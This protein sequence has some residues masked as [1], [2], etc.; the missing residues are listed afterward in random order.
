MEFSFHLA[1]LVYAAGNMD[2][3]RDTYDRIISTCS[4][5]D[6]TANY[7]VFANALIA[8]VVFLLEDDQL[9][10]A[11]RVIQQA[12]ELREKFCEGNDFKIAECKVML[13]RCMQQEDECDYMHC[14]RLLQEALESAHFHFGH[15]HAQVAD[16][17]FSLA[18]THRNLNEFEESL[19]FHHISLHILKIIFGE[20]NP[21]AITAAGSVGITLDKQMQFESSRIGTKLKHVH[22]E[23]QRSSVSPYN[24]MQKF[25]FPWIR[26]Q[27]FEDYTE[28]SKSAKKSKGGD[29]NP[30]QQSSSGGEGSH[31]EKG[32]KLLIRNI[33]TTGEG[34]PAEFLLNRGEEL[35]L[36]DCDFASAKVMFE[37]CYIYLCEAL[38][39]HHNETLNAQYRIADSLRELGDYDG[40]LETYQKCVKEYIS[41]AG[42]KIGLANAMAGWAET[43]LLIGNFTMAKQKF[44]EALVN[45]KN[46]QQLGIVDYVD[47][48]HCELGLVKVLEGDSKYVEAVRLLDRLLKKIKSEHGPHHKYFAEASLLHARCKR[49]KGS[50]AEVRASL[51]Q[52]FIARRVLY[53]ED[54]LYF[55]YAILENAEYDF[56]MGN[57]EDALSKFDSVLE[58]ALNFLDEDH[59]YVL[60]IRV[61]I[62]EVKLAQGFISEA[63]DEHEDILKSVI[64]ILGPDSGKVGD[65]YYYI[66]NALL[67]F[68]KHTEAESAFQS[69]MTIYARTYGDAHSKMAALKFSLAENCRLQGNLD[70]S[71]ELHTDVLKLRRDIYGKEHP[72]TVASMFA[73]QSFAIFDENSLTPIDE[74]RNNLTKLQNLQK[75]YYGE[76]HVTYLNSIIAFAELY[77]MYHL[78]P[79]AI[80]KYDEAIR[81]CNVLYGPEHYLIPHLTAEIAM[82]NVMNV[83]KVRE[84]LA[85][86][87]FEKEQLEAR[88]ALNRSGSRARG[89]EDSVDNST[90]TS[91]T[92]VP[93]ADDP[94]D[95]IVDLTPVYDNSEY[96]KYT[97]KIQE[98]IDAML[99]IFPETENYVHPFVAHLRGNI[100]IIEKLEEDGRR[101]FL[102]GLTRKEKALYKEAAEKKLSE[103]F[104]SNTADFSDSLPGTVV[105]N[106]A[107][108]YFQEHGFGAKHKWVQKF[109]TVLKSITSEKVEGTE[110]GNVAI[111][112]ATRKLKEARSNFVRGDLDVARDAYKETLERLPECATRPEDPV[113]FAM[114]GEC[115]CGLGDIYRYQCLMKEAREH[116]VKSLTILR[117]IDD[118]DNDRYAMAL[119]GYSDLLF[120]EGHFEECESTIDEA[121]N[122]KEKIVDSH[123]EEIIDIQYRRV[124]L[125][126][127][128]GR[129]EIGM[130]G[131]Q[132]ILDTRLR[133]MR[134]KDNM[135]LQLKIAH[136][137]NA[138]AEFSILLAQHSEADNYITLAIKVARS[139]IDESK[140][141]M[142]IADSYHLRG[143]LRMVEGK[144]KEALRNFGHALAMKMRLLISLKKKSEYDHLLDEDGNIAKD[145]PIDPCSFLHTT[146]AISLY[147]QA[148]SLRR[149][150]KF[151]LASEL[152]A[153]SAQIVRELFGD[154]D[155]P[156]TAAVWFSQAENFRL[157]GEYS[158][159]DSL[160][161]KSLEMRNRLFP[162]KHPDKAN[163][164]I[165]KGCLLVEQC[166]YEEAYIHFESALE[167]CIHFYGDLHPLTA[168]AFVHAADVDQKLGRFTLADVQF[169]K[170]IDILKPKFGETHALLCPALYGLAESFHAQEK[171]KDADVLYNLITSVIALAY[172]E[173][174]PDVGTFSVGHANNLLVQGRFPE[175]KVAA[176]RAL[177]IFN[178]VF[179]AEHAATI[180]ALLAV[181]RSLQCAGRYEKAYPYFQRALVYIKKIFSPDIRPHLVVA[182]CLIH[183]GEC[184]NS[185]GRY[186]EALS[187]FEQAVEIRRALLG[188]NHPFT[189]MALSSAAM[190]VQYLGELRKAE[191]WHNE[192]LNTSMEISGGAVSL[193]VAQSMSRL[194]E[195]IAL[196]GKLDQAKSFH[197]RVLKAHV[198]LL[199]GRHP[200]VA[201]SFLA[202]GNICLKMD[203][204][205]EAR[206]HFDKSLEL[207]RNIHREH[208][209]AIAYSLYGIAEC[210]RQM[211]FHYDAQESYFE[212]IQLLAMEAGMEYPPVIKMMYGFALNRLAL[213]RV[214][215]YEDGILP[216][217][218]PESEVLT[219]DHAFTPSNCEEL[220]AFPV[221]DKAISF[222]EGL[223]GEVHHDVLEGKSHLVD[224]YLSM[225]LLHNAL[226][227]QK[228][229]LS[230][231]KIHFGKDFIYM[232]PVLYKL[233]EVESR[234]GKIIPKRKVFE[235][236]GR[237]DFSAEAIT[238][239]TETKKKKNT[240][241]ILPKISAIDSK[242]KGKSRPYGYMGCQF[243]PV[244]TRELDPGSPVDHLVLNEIE[245]ALRDMSNKPPGAAD[246]VFDEDPM[247]SMIKDSARLFDI[248]HALH[249]ERYKADYKSNAFTATIFQGKADL[250]R[251]RHEFDDA[252]VLYKAALQIRYKCLRTGHPLIA[253]SL[254]GLAENYRMMSKVKD[255]IPLYEQSLVMRKEAFG[256]KEL[257]Y[258]EHVSIGESKLGL[259]LAFFDQ[260]LYLDAV[261]PCEYSLLVRR[262]GLGTENIVTISSEIA[263]ANILSALLDHEKATELYEHALA[264]T[265]QIFGENHIQTISVKNNYAHSLKAQ[266]LL[267]QALGLYEEILKVQEKLYGARHPDIASSYNNIGA[268]FF[269]RGKY[270]DA[271][272]YYRQAVEMKRECFGNESAVV[273]SSLHNLGGVLHS[274]KRFDE[275]KDMYEEALMIRSTLFNYF[276]PCIADTLNNIGI[277]LFSMKHFE[278]AE[279]VYNRALDIKEKVYGKDHVAYAA[280]LHNVAVLLH[281]MNRLDEARDA[282]TTCLLIQEEKLGPEHP[283]AS[284]TRNS[285]EALD[286]EQPQEE[287]Y[288]GASGI[289]MENNDNYNKM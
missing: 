238:S 159:A 220:W 4:K 98:S 101:E 242:K 173:G 58:V 62:A 111:L 181:A 250:L 53:A 14:K 261:E 264:V 180:K 208:H 160:Y 93:A 256:E 187:H 279:S 270:S 100:G 51:D 125:D 128:L 76:D 96:E 90:I 197:E 271:L 183:N 2:F 155:N 136:T 19:H 139:Q 204:Y 218:S 122:I 235:K 72:E 147:G 99:R 16:I 182:E 269:A 217:I 216:D 43:A 241:V 152:F 163:A 71:K 120:M 10:D 40:A 229:L 21:V 127:K 54:H 162:S 175:A 209:P 188:A 285:L 95:E 115:L 26:N 247:N 206:V 17:C 138:L 237:P 267:D 245:N 86:E 68:G 255:A 112:K 8:N 240:K 262:Y 38:S 161:T 142:T 52:T 223:Y 84:E 135:E 114:A 165:G 265:S 24:A 73:T 248:A 143:E 189:V 195:T 281:Y 12:L 236:L 83:E 196:L 28:F 25:L 205:S 179:G 119:L 44:S 129:Y 55:A 88:R 144:N 75:A 246:I 148:E 11:K 230:A 64:H 153:K 3:P 234:M 257:K 91:A 110:P 277:L 268:V 150:G 286:S 221:L 224:M 169:N 156:I 252:L 219:K 157:F 108:A 109:T 249:S 33:M 207:N 154:D 227:L 9:L 166:R 226:A 50:F 273:A 121:L 82:I 39:P 289:E 130:D 123:S 145:A 164:M 198:S 260:G 137:Y 105:L 288:I 193:L 146:V 1:K 222:L 74:K 214:Y 66:G 69:A 284:S 201:D 31:D 6:N 23:L 202:L 22:I 103:Q 259:S 239:G 287:D 46:V 63:Y 35:L 118:K 60:Q 87:K 124:F 170:A 213:G 94:P 13:C 280:T 211:G 56:C 126:L 27:F 177:N 210:T 149:D 251:S 151:Q 92:T 61:R 36:E 131:C 254:F 141:H 80:S 20:K 176:Q 168:E 81:I 89:G 133:M 29:D 274:L 228:R 34:G 107:L 199:G 37:Q 70:R 225:G 272:P 132:D 102:M 77:N 59:P 185:L 171:Y 18:L 258:D 194:A 174:H 243:A 79:E 275:A 15:I 67:L 7:E 48:F 263:M 30:Q 45:L 282:Y 134:D 5:E 42:S 200:L 212:A 203:S 192:T 106:V 231:Y 276:H 47:T 104:A 140:D 32:G 190:S 85:R 232:A 186:S 57:Y 215:P 172:G 78:H 158:M 233:A 283:D 191:Q 49:G 41:N 244:K 178:K 266:G 116:Y 184:L 97:S 117:K 65:S 278:E 253:Q 113:V 167:L